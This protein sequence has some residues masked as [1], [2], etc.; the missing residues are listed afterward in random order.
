MQEKKRKTLILQSADISGGKS[1]ANIKLNEIENNE[2][3]EIL[4]GK[5]KAMESE[6]ATLVTFVQAEKEKRS[7]GLPRHSR[8]VSAV[9]TNSNGKRMQTSPDR[10]SNRFRLTT[11]S[12]SPLKLK[13]DQ[14]SYTNPDYSPYTLTENSSTYRNTTNNGLT[15]EGA[16]EEHFKRKLEKG[17]NYLHLPRAPH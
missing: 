12:E 10:R 9:S 3:N 4:G 6:L 11:E 14:S 17:G 15:F 13:K 2:Q 8:T 7:A 16:V 1:I 5:L